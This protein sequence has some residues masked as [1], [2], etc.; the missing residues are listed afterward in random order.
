MD[1]TNFFI[2]EHLAY[3]VIS[4][5]LQ[6]CDRGPKPRAA[7]AQGPNKTPVKCDRLNN[8]DNKEYTNGK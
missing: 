7:H 2:T 5:L 4:P 1:T 6:G 3:V 8:F